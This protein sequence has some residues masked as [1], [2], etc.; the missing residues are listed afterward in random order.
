MFT[1]ILGV[2]SYFIFIPK[3]SYWGAAYTTLF[4]EFLIVIFSY[5]VVKKYINIKIDFKVLIKS[6]LA[7]IITFFSIWQ[8]REFNIF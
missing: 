6:L 7:G 3:F 5:M 1:A 2:V 8:W 4:V